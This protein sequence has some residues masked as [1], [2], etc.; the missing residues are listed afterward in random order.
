MSIVTRKLEKLEERIG[1]VFENKDL[2]VKALTHSSYG[3]GRRKTD[4]N[5]RLEFLGDRILGLMTAEKLFVLCPGK[6]GA[7]ARRLN[8]LV[9]KETCARIA[10]KVGMGEALQLSPSEDRQGGRDKNSILGDA[11]EAIIAAIYLD[12]GRSAVQEFYDT[13]WAEE[14]ERVTEKSQKD[15][16]TE[17]QERA[18]M[19]G[20]H[21]PEYVMMDRSGP[22]HRPSFTVEV[23][24]DTVGKAQGTGATKKIAERLAAKHLLETWPEKV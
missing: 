20:G 10:R 2:A 9:R 22:D 7:L 12:G 21:T 8:A 23:I 1:Y 18:V 4:D 15:P 24:V 14:I 6:E 16:K 11:C 19:E 3:D 13:H 5:E 17:L